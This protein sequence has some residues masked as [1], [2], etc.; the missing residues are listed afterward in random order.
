MICVGSPAY[1]SGFFGWNLPLYATYICMV[2]KEPN[3]DQLDTS[4]GGGGQ[5]GIYSFPKDLLNN[6]ETQHYILFEI[7]D[8]ESASVNTTKRSVVRT[9][10]DAQQWTSRV[11][12]ERVYEQRDPSN[13]TTTIGGFFEGARVTNAGEEVD[14]SNLITTLGT[15]I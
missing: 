11:R 3:M 4:V 10:D 13:V 9:G 12:N 7:Y 8:D 14:V 1:L 2:S 5:A 15:R 6:P